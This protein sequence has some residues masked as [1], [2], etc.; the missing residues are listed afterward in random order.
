LGINNNIGPNP[1]PIKPDAYFSQA[2]IQACVC[3][4]RRY[5]G[6]DLLAMLKAMPLPMY[7]IQTDSDT[8]IH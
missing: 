6:L 7:L 5:H 1:I 3:F 8:A 4:M 2:E